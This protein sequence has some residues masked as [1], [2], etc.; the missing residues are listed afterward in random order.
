VALDLVGGLALLQPAARDELL[1]RNATQVAV[2]HLACCSELTCRR[3][4]LQALHCLVDASN[5]ATGTAA[6]AI[7]LLA[8][9]APAT[10]SNSQQQQQQQ[11]ERLGSRLPQSHQAQRPPPALLRASSS[12]KK[13]KVCRFIDCT[14]SAQT[15]SWGSGC[16]LQWK[17]TH[18]SQWQHGIP[19]SVHFS[20]R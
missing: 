3:A 7:L 10:N 20:T 11:E 19:G 14:A 17:Q 12:T 6:A 4:A 8:D 2:D 5:A 18:G 15:L 1:R 9:L 13:G 16:R